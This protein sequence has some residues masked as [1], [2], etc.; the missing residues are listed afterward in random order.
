MGTLRTYT[1]RLNGLGYGT[2]VNTEPRSMAEFEKSVD[3]VINK[4]NQAGKGL[5]SFDPE[6]GKNT[7]ATAPG[8]D[9]V[10]NAM[11]YTPSERSNLAKALFALSSA[12][13]SGV[14]QD[15]KT[16]FAAR[17]PGRQQPNVEFGS[18]G[19]ESPLARVSNEKIGRGKNQRNVKAELAKLS[20]PD[21]AKPFI[22][23]VAGETPERAKFISAKARNMSP[24]QRAKAYGY[25]NAEIANEVERRYEEDT[26]LRAQSAAG[27]SDPVA[28]Q[29]RALDS[30][31]ATQGRQVEQQ[32]SDI[33]IEKLK[34]LAAEGKLS[35]P[36]DSEFDRT[37]YRRQ[38]ADGIPRGIP[39][40]FGGR[41]PKNTAQPIQDAAAPQ[42]IA[43]V[44]GDVTGSQPAPA[45]DAGRGGWMGGGGSGRVV[46]PF[47]PEPEEPKYKRMGYAFQPDG[48][49]RGA[50]DRREVVRGIER[51]NARRRVGYG[52]AGAGVAAGLAALISG[53]R[54]EREEAMV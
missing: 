22:G 1:D 15:S 52:A 29:Q 10:L 14:N 49:S 31:F 32:K 35:V 54:E 24:E 38:T 39:S 18:I 30:S 33:E 48:A 46:N 53:E 21:A 40:I 19:E 47:A 6:T 7:P 20:D 8:V 23:A 44:P 45:V 13:L 42:S 43:P 36:A 34:R 17:R 16:D 11:R 27:Q 12:Q 25:K 50:R 37:V 3:F 51:Q 28:E 41:M 4:S 9:E 2:A 26:N 5:F